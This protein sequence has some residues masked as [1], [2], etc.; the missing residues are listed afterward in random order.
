MLHQFIKDGKL[1]REALLPELRRFL[2]LVIAQ[3]RLELRYQVSATE[4]ADGEEPG[5]LVRFE[6]RDSDLLLQ[7][8]AELLNALEY[9]AVRWLRL[10]PH[11][12]D[13]VRLDCADYRQT[14][15]EELKLTARVAA[16]R[17]VSSR[18][19]FR[20]NPM[21][22][23]ERRVVHLALKDFP[24]VRTAS[25]GSGDHRQVVIYPA[26]AKPEGNR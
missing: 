21:N 15:L 11:F 5:V 3:L 13:H 4:A 24:G 7:H 6:G 26:D 22:S 20:L 12:Y 16:E 19:S 25:D 14:H 10:D 8:H 18:Q 1:D 2:D 9:L 23:R 17:V